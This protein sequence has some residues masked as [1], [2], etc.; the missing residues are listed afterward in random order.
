MVKIYCQPWG[1]IAVDVN[2]TKI[3]SGSGIAPEIQVELAQHLD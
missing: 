2:G 1:Q 3:S